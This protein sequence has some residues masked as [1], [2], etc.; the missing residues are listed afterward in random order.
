MPVDT[1]DP[2]ECTRCRRTPRGPVA[3]PRSLIIVTVWLAVIV[4]AATPARAHSKL[5]QSV[6][7][8]RSVVGESPSRVRLSFN[9]RI[10]PAYAE[11]SVWVDGG[12][13]VDTGDVTVDP[14]NPV[15]MSVGL[16]KLPPGRYT[17]RYRV[18]SVDG[19]VVKGSLTFTVKPP[20]GGKRTP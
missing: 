3:R 11:L 16:G 1:R 12:K 20:Q 5:L 18:V 13:Q 14:A 10:E 7:A 15:A 6:P 9:E 2:T 4:C 8:D 19:H 17:V